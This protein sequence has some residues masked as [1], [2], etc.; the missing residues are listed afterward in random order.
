MGG[1]QAKSYTDVDDIQVQIPG[2]AFVKRVE[3]D[4]GNSYN[5]YKED[6]TGLKAIEA[7]LAHQNDSRA[8]KKLV[9]K[10]EAKLNALHPH[11]QQMLCF[12]NGPTFMTALFEYIDHDLERDIFGRMTKRQP[13]TE[14]E[15]LTIIYSVSAAGKALSLIHI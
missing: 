3:D 6:Q 2:F 9:E 15:L 12:V 5:L 14:K 11:L 10:A 13:Y 1:S 8:M 7:R 4:R